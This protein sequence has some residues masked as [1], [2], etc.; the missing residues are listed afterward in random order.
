MKK[1]IF[2]E[3]ANALYNFMVENLLCQN[4]FKSVV[5][6]YSLIDKISLL[7]MN[8]LY[9]FAVKLKTELFKIPRL[10]YTFILKWVYYTV[11]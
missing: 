2:F 10:F 3:R 11:F 8:A 1:K 7:L 9:T 6:N 4:W 5:Y